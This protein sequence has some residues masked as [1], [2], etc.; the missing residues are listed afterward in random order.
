ML[1]LLLLLLLLPASPCLIREVP[2]PSPSCAVRSIEID[3]SIQQGRT[4]RPL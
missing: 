2:S 4:P 3:G 1:L